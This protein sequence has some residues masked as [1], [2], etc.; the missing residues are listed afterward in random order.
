[1]KRNG[2]LLHWMN[3]GTAPSEISMHLHAHRYLN[4][5]VLTH[6]ISHVYVLTSRVLAHFFKYDNMQPPLWSPFQNFASTFPISQSYD[7]QT[8]ESVYDLRSK[9]NESSCTTKLTYTT[10]T[11]LQM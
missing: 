6:D 4:V 1:M 2:F 11:E 7:R 5:Q 10:E 3:K 8:K 9:I